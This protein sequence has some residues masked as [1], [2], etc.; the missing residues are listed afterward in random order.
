[1]DLIYYALFT[2]I[3]EV[4]WAILAPFIREWPHRGK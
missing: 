1:M 4:L 3:R 2:P